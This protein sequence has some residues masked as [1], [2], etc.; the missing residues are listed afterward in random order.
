MLK[1]TV[2]LNKPLFVGQ[3]ILDISKAMMCE[4]WYGYIKSRYGE[5]ARLLYTDTSSVYRPITCIFGTI[6]R[7]ATRVR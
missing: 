3:A 2:T 1:G 4:F 6:L 7:T 5:K